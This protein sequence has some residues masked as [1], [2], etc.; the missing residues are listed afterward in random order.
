MS[1]ILDDFNPLGGTG[2]W[3]G[4]GRVTGAWLGAT[5]MLATSPSILVDSPAP[6]PADVAWYY[7]NAR[8][9]AYLSKKGGVIGSQLDNYLA[10]PVEPS[11]G[12]WGNEYIAPK[13]SNKNKPT[14]LDTSG[15]GSRVKMNF[16]LFTGNGLDFSNI[17]FA[18]NI[19]TQIKTLAEE[20]PGIAMGLQYIDRD[21][22]WP[23]WND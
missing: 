8:N 6:G 22:E 1:F 16:D 12:T 2:Y 13:T 15:Y 21:S 4:T 5:M 18:M 20:I 3:E 9:I 17:K 7:A 19:A 23:E 11:E 10:E 14:T